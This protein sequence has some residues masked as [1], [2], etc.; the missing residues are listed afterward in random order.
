MSELV[1]IQWFPGH[2][3]KT[4]RLIK[5]S[6][7][8]VDCVAEI[9]DARIPKSS[10]NPE[11]DSLCASKPRILLLNKSDVSDPDANEKWIEHCKKSGIGAIAVDCKSGK[12][13]NRFIPLVKGILK[14]KIEK[15]AQKG[16]AGRK[17][18]IMVVGVPNCGKSTFINRMA[19]S[20]RLKT[21]DRPGVTRGRTWIDLGGNFEM[22]DTPGMLWPKFEDPKVGEKLA[23]CGAVKDD[24][25]DT[26]LL[27]CRLLETLAPSYPEL[28]KARYKLSGELPR[29]GYALLELIGRKRG[30]LI[31]GGEVDTERAS[32]IVL[33]EFRSGKIGRITLETP[34]DEG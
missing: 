6:L 19:G 21:E 18:R 4:R 24:V 33:D 15:N 34:N 9:T 10:R 22:M 23:F 17:I 7:P 32:I 12:G 14:D 29:E 1:S 30:M 20:N 13:L 31:S 26:E 25:I 11:I 28:L 27:S 8:L 5:E 3:A 2:M 16:M